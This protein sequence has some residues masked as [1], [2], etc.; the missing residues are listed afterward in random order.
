[1]IRFRLNELLVPRLKALRVVS[2]KAVDSCLQLH[3][4]IMLDI[5]V[6]LVSILYHIM[7]DIKVMSTYVNIYY[8]HPDV[9]TLRHGGYASSLNLLF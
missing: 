2:S 7:F 4:K 8:N 9:W 6:M 5:K 1:M 3:G